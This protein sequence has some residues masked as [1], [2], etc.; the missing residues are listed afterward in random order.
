MQGGGDPGLAA[1]DG[2]RRDHQGQ[3]ALTLEHRLDGG[4]DLGRLEVLN[5][6]FEQGQVGGRGR[7]DQVVI[8]RAEKGV[9]QPRRAAGGSGLDGVFQRRAV[10][11]DLAIQF[12]LGDSEL[13]QAALLLIDGFQRARQAAGIEGGRDGADV[14]AV[15]QA[16]AAGAGLDEGRVVGAGDFA[17]AA[18]QDGQ[19]Q[20][21][22][23]AVA[24]FRNRVGVQ[25]RIADPVQLD[26]RLDAGFDQDAGLGRAR[27]DG[28]Q[29]GIGAVRRLGLPVGEGRADLGFHLINVEVADSD[30][31]RAFGAVIGVVELDEAFTR[32]RADDAEVA[33][34]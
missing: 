3:G 5:R 12:D 32:G 9:G 6:R 8:G 30:H 16:A 27:S 4:V 2:F 26:R 34:R 31:G 21:L 11:G 33:D 24:T 25:I 17:Q 14:D 23:Q 22:Q 7:E 29:I 18:I 1:F 15:E 20:V 28:S 13:H 10:V 19:P